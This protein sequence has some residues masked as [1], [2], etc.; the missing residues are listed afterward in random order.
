MLSDKMQQEFNE[1]INN[2]FYAWYLYTSMAAYFESKNFPGFTNY[3]KLQAAEEMM[4]AMKNYG[5]LLE[6]GGKVE[7][8]TIDGVP[9]D[10]D[11]PL[12]AFE[13][14]LA[15]EEKVTAI[16]NNFMDVAKEEK[17]HAA[18]IMI[19]WFINEQVEEEANAN[20]V[21]ERLKMAKDSPGGLFIIDQEL[22][23]RQPAPGPAQ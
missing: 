13:A 3:M 10:W 19:Q 9:N 6:R 23:K 8:K 14:A 21:V 22:G 4:H 20:S 11:S 1:R 12:A 17:D 5:Y 7:L 16:Y 2:E 15:H 18:Q